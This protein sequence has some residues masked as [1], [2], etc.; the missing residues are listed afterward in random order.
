MP[1]L[2]SLAADLEETLAE[3]SATVPKPAGA[4]SNGSTPE[5]EGARATS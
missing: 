3:L 1:L 4:K 5:R 2:D